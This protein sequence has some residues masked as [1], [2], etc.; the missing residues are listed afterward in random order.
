MP[1]PTEYTHPINVRSNQME[2]SRRGG[3]Q[4]DYDDKIKSAQLELE[5]IQQEREELERKKREL[6]ELTSRKRAFLAQ[7]VELTEKL[8]TS[9]T[10]IDRELY[11]M[12][13]ETSHLEQ[14][15]SC[16]AE[17]LDKI[18]KHDPEKWTRDNLHEKLDKA[19]IVTDLAADEYDQAAAY[20]ENTRAGAIFGRASKGGRRRAKA[21]SGESEFKSQLM[22]GLAFNLPVVVLGGLAL[23]AYLIK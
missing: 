14:C 8:S 20:F 23:I 15:R 16:F 12:R 5:R 10:L 21:I 13:E 3:R 2:M 9:L 11:E 19:M 7:Q 6:E 4:D 1:A 17:H 22:N 18:Q